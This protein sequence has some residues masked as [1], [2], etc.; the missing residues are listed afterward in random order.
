MGC[1]FCGC[2]FHVFVLGTTPFGLRKRGA[3]NGYAWPFLLQVLCTCA[4]RAEGTA[5]PSAHTVLL[6]NER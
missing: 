3:R 1:W 2:C 5:N 6:G 4:P